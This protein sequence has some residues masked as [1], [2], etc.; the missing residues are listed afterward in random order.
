MKAVTIGVGAMMAGIIG[1]EAAQGVQ[2]VDTETAFLD[3][4]VIVHEIDTA[5]KTT[6]PPVEIGQ[7]TDVGPEIEM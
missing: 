7:G 3:L 6:D 1:E 5:M 2:I 4:T